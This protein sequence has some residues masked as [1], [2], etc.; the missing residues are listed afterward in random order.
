MSI[1]VVGE[2]FPLLGKEPRGGG[3]VRKQ[4]DGEYSF[5][6]VVMIFTFPALGGFLFGTL[7]SCI[8]AVIQQHDAPR[9]LWYYF[10]QSPHPHSWVCVS[11][12]GYDIGATSMTLVQMQSSSYSG[13]LWYDVVASSSVLQGVITSIG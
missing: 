10:G 1:E 6:G 3:E 13:T 12:A 4:G 5:W 9:C 11:C 8:P 2:N 7:F